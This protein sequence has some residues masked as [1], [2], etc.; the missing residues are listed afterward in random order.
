[1][2]VPDVKIRGNLPHIVGAEA[3]N[4]ALPAQKTQIVRISFERR[5]VADVIDAQKNRI[6]ISFVRR[7]RR[8]VKLK[9]AKS[10]T[11][12]HSASRLIVRYYL[13]KVGP[14]VSRRRTSPD[15][16]KQ[17]NQESLQ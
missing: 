11:R 8:V 17:R 2:E 13:I 7:R 3:T 10:P 14:I 1:V 4:V 15:H 12:G 9:T 5:D 6:F 16:N